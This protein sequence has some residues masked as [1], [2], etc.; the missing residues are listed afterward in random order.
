MDLSHTQFGA[1]KLY[2]IETGRFRLDAG[3][4][5]GV[6][7]KPLWSRYIDVDDKN[8][9]LM[10]SRCLLIESQQTGAIY[11]ID[12]GVGSKLN[13]KMAAIYDINYEHSDLISSLSYHGFSPDDVTDIIFTHLH[14]DHCGGTT[15]YDESGTIAHTFQHAAYH[16]TKKHWQTAT[17]PNAREKA[18][19]LSDNIDPLADSGRLHLIEERHQFEEGLSTLPAEGHTLGQQLPKVDAGGRSIVFAADLLPTHV[20]LPLA[21]VMVYDMRPVQTLKEK[22]AFLDEAIEEGWYLFMEHDPDREVIRV[23]RQDGKYAVGSTLGLDD[24]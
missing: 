10:A 3:A 8:R 14:F 17:E 11:L 20:H 6:V 15:F 7:P 23:R 4:M 19:F 5:F 9:M 24:I 13:D 16:I 1:F 21:W 12:N 22:E 2:T 18:S